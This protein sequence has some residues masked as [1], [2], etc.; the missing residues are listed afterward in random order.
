[1]IV[2]LTGAS[3]FIG[4]HVDAYLESIGFDILPISSKTCNLLDRDKTIQLVK[5][6]K[7]KYIVHLAANANGNAG[8]AVIS[9]NFNMTK[10]LLDA[11]VGIVDKFVFGSSIVVYAG[12]SN[13]QKEDGILSPTSYYGISK[14]LCDNLCDFYLRYHQLKTTSLRMCA[15]VGKGMTHGLLK[16]VIRKVKEADKTIE[17][18]GQYPGSRKPYVHVNDVSYIIGK[19]LKEGYT[20]PAINISSNNIPV[21]DVAE[22]VMSIVGKYPEI[23]W[24]EEKVWKGDNPF[25]TADYSKLTKEYLMP[26][27][28]INAIKQATIEE[29]ENY[30]DAPKYVSDR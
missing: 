27:S 13:P 19:V 11:S 14:V 3:G 29:L 1:M 23:N 25:L 12:N 5:D 2:L 15:I 16:D 26:Q 17:L 24:N 7:P 6:V 22:A 21:K 28:S 18:F 4:K 9:D 20:S 8:D 30:K 10:N